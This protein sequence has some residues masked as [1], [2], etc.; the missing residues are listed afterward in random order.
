MLQEQNDKIVQLE[1]NNKKFMENYEKIIEN[2]INMRIS[3]IINSYNRST[4]DNDE[5]IY[6]MM[7]R[8]DRRSTNTIG[9]SA[10]AAPG[11]LDYNNDYN[12]IIYDSPEKL[13]EQ[14]TLGENS[15]E[16]ITTFCNKNKIYMI[17]YSTCEDNG[18]NNCIK[19]NYFLKNNLMNNGNQC[20]EKEKRYAHNNKILC[21]NYFK[22]NSKDLLISS[23]ADNYIKIW[24]ITN[25]EKENA[26]IEEEKCINMKHSKI[27]TVIPM[28]RRLINT[29]YLITLKNDDNTINII[30]MNKGDLK[31]SIQEENEINN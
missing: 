4:T 7:G 3:N 13:K 30:D 17:A 29:N 21:I 2:N 24:N 26:E 15:N 20:E 8:G 11:P 16:C 27:H 23:S 9:K 6:P 1:Q 19:V 28:S 22:N 14:L 18:K 10:L 25:I 5:G 12:N 31:Q